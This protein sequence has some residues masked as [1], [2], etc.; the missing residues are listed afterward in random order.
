MFAWKS[1]KTNFLNRPRHKDVALRHTKAVLNALL[2]NRTVDE[3]CKTLDMEFDEYARFQTLKSLAVADGSLT[4]EEGMTIYAA[5]GE[6][7][8]TFN[9]QPVHIKVVLTNFFKE[10][11][12]KVA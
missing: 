4:T 1:A 3:V 7:P 11:L 9:K 12:D 5:L 10:L 8:N 2:T 6:Q